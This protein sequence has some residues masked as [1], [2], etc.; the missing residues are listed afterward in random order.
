MLLYKKKSEKEV[1]FYTKYDKNML[2]FFL[3]TSLS[4]RAKGGVRDFRLEK[5]KNTRCHK[6]KAAPCSDSD[7]WSWAA[8]CAAGCT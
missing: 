8:L 2:S 1:K 4:H 3:P 6:S 5:K 7:G